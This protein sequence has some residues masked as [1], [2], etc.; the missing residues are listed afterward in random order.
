[1]EQNWKLPKWPFWL[2]DFLLLGLAGFVVW[3]MPHP[4]SMPAVVLCIALCAFGGIVGS[5]PF[6]LEYRAFLK[7]VEVNALGSVVAQIQNLEKV[8]AQISDATNRWAAVQESVAG[9][10]DKTAGSAKAIAD[11]MSEEVRQFSAFMEQINDNE[12]VTLRLEVEK[13]RRGEAEWLQT[14][15]RILD[16]IF[17]LHAAAVRSG[18][19]KI[20][21][22]LTHFQNACRGVIRRLGLVAFAGEQNEP[23]NPERHQAADGVKT[24]A[25]SVVGETVAAGYTFQGKLLRPALVK[26]HDKKSPP[27]EPAKSADETTAE[28]PLSEAD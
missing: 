9:Q 24:D 28:L 23:F 3:R 15:V 27:E 19:P 6:I 4:I 21:E 12:K 1:M 13:L 20:A 14:V 2:T 8:S 10:A 18:Q 22:Q 26:V 17:A 7:T 25:D 11:R 5:L 16:H